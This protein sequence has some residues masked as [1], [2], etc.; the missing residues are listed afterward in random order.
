[1]TNH[2]LYTPSLDTIRASKGWQFLEFVENNANIKLQSDSPEQSYINLHR[3]SVDNLGLFHDLA[4]N[5]C[6]LIGDKG[7]ETLINPDNMLEAAFF[8]QA[9]ISYA[10]NMLARAKTHPNDPAIIARVAG[11]EKDKI[12]SWSELENQVSLWEQALKS[13]GVAENDRISTYLPHISEAYIIHIAAS[14]IGAIFSSVGTEMG[15]EAAAERYKQIKPKVL[16]AVDGYIHMSPKGEK[17][18]DRLQTLKTIQ[19]ELSDLEHTILIPNLGNQPDIN[20][21][22][23]TQLSS[24]LLSK[25]KPQNIEFIRRDFSHPLAILFS[26]GSTGKPKCFVHGT[27]NILLKHAIEHQLNSDVREGDRE[28]YHTTTSWMMFNWL[29]GGLAQGATILIFDGNPAYPDNAAHLDFIASYQATHLGTAAGLIQDV[30]RAGNVIYDTKKIVSLKSISYTGSVLSAEGFE[31]INKNIKKDLS[32]NGICGG[33]D[34]VG[35]YAGGNSFMPTIAGE[36]KGPILGMAVECWDD[37][38]K[39]VKEGEVGELVITKPFISRPLYFWGDKKTQA[40]PYGERFTDSYFNHY[41]NSGKPIWRHGDSVRLLKNGQLIVEGRSDSTLNQNGV[42][43]GAQM[44]YDALDAPEIKP[45]I[46]SSIA[47]SFKDAEG[48]DHT[49]LFICPK[50]DKNELNEDL[51][52]TIKAVI[53]DKVGRLCVPHEIIAVP[54]ILS[55]PNGKKAEKPAKQALAGQEITTPETYGNDPD[56]GAY[57]ADLFKDIGEKLRQKPQYGFIKE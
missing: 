12:L 1:M 28:F 20:S 3:W 19:A 8:P 49:A 27:G 55:T 4:W 31:Y 40:Q 15:A 13:L 37:E 56:T 57:K 42:R 25:F 30:W 52:K 47:V 45:Y 51:L 39:P 48:G 43:I 18:E 26:S 5:F 11:Q 41:T 32:I 33:T 10:E 46:T 7:G 21:L 36:L 34:F 2:T 6:G 50:N 35:C 29:A 16:I 23:N 22:Q 9:K 24:S 38:G 53:S 54:Y 17:H 44:L 14:N